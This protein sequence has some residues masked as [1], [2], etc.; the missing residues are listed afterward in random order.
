M[1]NKKIK[2]LVYNSEHHIK[3]PVQLLAMALMK[4]K[5]L[6]GLRIFLWLKFQ[7]GR[8][9]ENLRSEK[10]N[11]AFLNCAGIDYPQNVKMIFVNIASAI[12]TV[13]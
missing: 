6:N 3:V 10:K 11:I 13:I 1:E 12:T 4:S 8:K 7:Y 2:L 9:I 5:D